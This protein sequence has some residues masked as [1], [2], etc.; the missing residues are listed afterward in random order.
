MVTA[1]SPRRSPIALPDSFPWHPL[2]ARCFAATRCKISLTPSAVRCPSVP[3]RKKY[4]VKSRENAAETA[5]LEPIQG[6]L[7][8]LELESAMTRQT[9]SDCSP[10]GVAQTVR[11][12]SIQRCF[13]NA[14][15]DVILV[16]RRNRHGKAQHIV[17]LFFKNCRTRSSRRCNPRTRCS[18]HAAMCID[19]NVPAF[20]QSHSL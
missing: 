14:A 1:S 16:I 7:S 9:R 20:I 4:T 15:H 2:P 8:S 10:P 13:P 18:R 12:L 5:V 11:E 17:D 19:A 6:S 3:S